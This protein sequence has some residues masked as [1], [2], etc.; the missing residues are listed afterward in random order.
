MRVKAVEG[1]SAGRPTVSTEI[2]VS[3]LGLVNGE[4][5]LIADTAEEFAKHILFMLSTPDRASNIAKSG[6]E[7]IMNKFSNKKIIS[8]LVKFLEKL[9]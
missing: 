9:N 1:M 5:A 8:D 2:G 4:H 3:G 7:H 6:Q